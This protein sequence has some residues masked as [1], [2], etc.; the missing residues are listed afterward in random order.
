MNTMQPLSFEAVDRAFSKQAEHYDDDDIANPILIAWRQQVYA[1]ADRFL[2]P[3]SFIL[4]LNAGT[5]IDAVRFVEHG[6]RVHATDLS[7]GM[8]KKINQKIRVNNLLGNL[9]CQQCS[10]ESLEQVQ[11]KKFDY[12]F[13]NFGGLN[14]A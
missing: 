8:I 1:H 7:D 12:I 2:K 3:N 13:S 14:C 10:F 6:H 9:S 4:E 5:G 11:E